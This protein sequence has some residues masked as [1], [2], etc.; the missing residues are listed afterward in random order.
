MAPSGKTGLEWS[1]VGWL[2]RNLGTAGV[3]LVVMFEE[4]PVAYLPYR[5]LEV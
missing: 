5:E 1:D 4:G 3:N 2:D